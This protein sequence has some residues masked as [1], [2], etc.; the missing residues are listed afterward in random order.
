MT[1]QSCRMLGVL[2]VV[3]FVLSAAEASSSDKPSEDT[4]AV[5]RSARSGAWS[6]AA[7]WEGDKTP[8][9]GSRVLI[10]EGHRIVYDVKSVQAIRA[11]HISS[12]LRFGPDR[13]TRLGVG[14]IRIQAGEKCSEEG[15][16][17]DA[18]VEA[19]DGAKPQAA[20][21]VGTPERPIDARHTALIRLKYFDGMDKESCP[22][23]ICCG[24]RMDFH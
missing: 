9:A 17:C 5:I 2:T 6:A 12:T 21:Q 7:T 23:I 24:G 8:G 20:L 1:D 11:I 19:P 16:D 22:A 13:D 10:R 18:H 3:L 4:A 14:L 15:F